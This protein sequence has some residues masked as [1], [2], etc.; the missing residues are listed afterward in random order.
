[1]SMSLYMRKLGE[2]G[3]QRRQ[4]KDFLRETPI[5]GL[6]LDNTEVLIITRLVLGHGSVSFT[7]DSANRLIEH[8]LVVLTGQVSPQGTNNLYDNLRPTDKLLEVVGPLV[9][10]TKL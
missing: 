7:A 10:Y 6:R 8:G 5:H 3:N 4:F 1:M 9:E 2:L